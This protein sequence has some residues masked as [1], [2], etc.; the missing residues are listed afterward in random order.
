MNLSNHTRIL[1]LVVG[2]A[3]TM[4]AA[5]C[6]LATPEQE[7]EPVFGAS[8]TPANGQAGEDDS[9]HMMPDRMPPGNM[10]PGMMPGANNSTNYCVGAGAPGS[11][12]VCNT[13]EGYYAPKMEPPDTVPPCV[14]DG[15]GCPEGKGRIECGERGSCQFMEGGATCVCEDGYVWTGSLCVKLPANVY[16]CPAEFVDRMNCDC[17]PNEVSLGTCEGSA[18]SLSC[19]C[20]L[21]GGETR[22]C[23]PGCDTSPIPMGICGG[24]EGAVCILVVDNSRV[25]PSCICPDGYT[26]V[27]EMMRPPRCVAE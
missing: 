20:E 14:R 5:G 26:L 17:C 13:S 11:D 9:D 22:A 18:G 7:S 6:L 2:A 23:L 19:T 21:G 24:V 27:R 10:M 8:V 16:E 25:G 15:Q 1:S 12:C 3:L 4:P